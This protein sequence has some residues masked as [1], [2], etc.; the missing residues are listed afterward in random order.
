MNQKI[1]LILA[2][3]WGGLFIREGYA[4]NPPA[5]PFFSRGIMPQFYASL[6][7]GVQRLSGRRSEIVNYEASP[8]NP[9]GPPET[10]N[11]SN[12]K[13]FSNK[14]GSYSGHVGCTW[15][16]PRTA[17]FL[18][19]ELYMG[20][21]STRNNLIVS[22]KD[23]NF[24]VR[25]L[26][27]TIRQSTFLGGALQVG[28][29]WISNS[30]L[31][32]LL[33]LEGSQFEY[34]GMYVPRSQ[35]ALSAVPGPGP[36]EDFPATTLNTSKWLSGFMWGLGVEKQIQSFRIGI[37]FR[38]VHYKEFK[39]SYTALAAEPETLYTVIKPKNIRF[40][41]KISYLF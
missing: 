6:S 16:I 23:Q 35:L 4:E 25:S 14:N 17:F 11:F 24:F 8:G 15:D 37:D 12:L 28:F 13:P 39:A 9:Y 41:L 26:N 30:R 27:A 32:L 3:V 1:L 29:N 20:Q 5:S 36:G 2:I 21:G 40:G 19:P 7:V 10:I 31:S 18:G 22:F 34:F 33:G 38:M